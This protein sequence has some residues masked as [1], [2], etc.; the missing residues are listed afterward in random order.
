MLFQQETIQ[1]I[2]EITSGEYL[3]ELVKFMGILIILV[4]MEAELL[5]FQLLPIGRRML[6]NTQSNHMM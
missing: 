1:E 6:T 4:D 2:L 5:P 3:K